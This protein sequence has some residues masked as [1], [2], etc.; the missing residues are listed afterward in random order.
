MYKEINRFP[1]LRKDLL[2]AFDIYAIFGRSRKGLIRIGAMYRNALLQRIPEGED[3][4]DGQPRPSE[5]LWG[6]RIHESFPP[7]AMS[8]DKRS[9]AMTLSV[10]FDHPSVNADL[11]G[12]VLEWFQFGTKGHLMPATDTEV[13]FWWGDPLKWPAPLINDIDMTGIHS[14]R[15]AKAWGKTTV[16]RDFWAKPYGDFEAEAADEIKGNEEDTVDR[17]YMSTVTKPLDASSYLRRVS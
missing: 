3:G 4:P 15:T 5:R 16:E 11:G 8:I 9:D 6:Q 1:A 17:V 14:S 10:L 12:D 13:A 2:A 7:P